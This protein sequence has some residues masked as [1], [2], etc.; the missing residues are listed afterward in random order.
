MQ[1]GPPAFSLSDRRTHCGG[2]DDFHHVNGKTR[3]DSLGPKTRVLLFCLFT[4]SGGVY[5]GI[6]APKNFSCVYTTKVFINFFLWKSGRAY[7]FFTNTP[8]HLCRKNGNDVVLIIK[9]RTFARDLLYFGKYVLREQSSQLQCATTTRVITFCPV[10]KTRW[11]CAASYRGLQD[12]I[13]SKKFT[14]ILIR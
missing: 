12:C 14:M 8:R 9:T 1:D 13:A 11:P 5:A 10:G 3:R 7:D 2:G 4:I 6:K